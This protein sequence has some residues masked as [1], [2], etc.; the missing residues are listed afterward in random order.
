MPYI[1]QEARSNLKIINISQ[2]DKKEIRVGVDDGLLSNP[3][4]LNFI[5]STLANMY[6]EANGLSYAKI[7]EVIGVLECAKLELYRRIAA[8]YEDA[9]IE[10]NGDVYTVHGHMKYAPSNQVS[11]I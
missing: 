11:F 9:K 4:N 2:Q 1:S 5:I 3:G 10:E 8:P 6:L 7:N